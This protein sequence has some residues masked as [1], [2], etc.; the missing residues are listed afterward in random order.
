M[1]QNLN[2]DG[3]TGV[4]PVGEK[5]MLTIREAAYYFNIGVKKIG[6]MS[7]RVIKVTF[8]SA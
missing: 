2:E 1:Q 8:V 4:I 6:S 7:V 5:Y 3:I